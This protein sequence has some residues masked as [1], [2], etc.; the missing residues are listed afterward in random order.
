M[1]NFRISLT[2]FCLILLLNAPALCLAQRYDYEI[3]AN[4]SPKRPWGDFAIKS[5]PESRAQSRSPWWAQVLLWIPNRV[6][7]FIDIFKVDAG[8]GPSFGA[9][10]RITRYGQV[11]YRSVS[12]L[13]VR[14]GLFGRRV[15]FMLENSSEFGIGPGY[16]SS[17]DRK[18]CKGEIGVGADLFLAGAY[19]GVCVDE[20]MDFIA[21]I[22]FLD[23]SGDDIK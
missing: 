23:V 15:P 16:V 14:A 13:S 1:I 7:D 8:V 19:G 6:M 22:F 10:V 18:V 9:V 5:E 17:D 20:L 2:V 12:P 21:G 4:A 11:G 3:D